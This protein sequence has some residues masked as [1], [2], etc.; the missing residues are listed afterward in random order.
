L[1]NALLSAGLSQRG[2][3]KATQIMS[4]EEV[5]KVL[6][7]DKIGRRNPDRYHFSVFGQPAENGIW[8]YRVE[9]HHVSLHF[10]IVNGKV[11]GAPTF[12]GANPHEV[13]T[14][15]RQGLR[16]LGREE[17]LARD[18]VSSLD[19]GQ[20]K[21][22]VV[23]E[24]AYKDIL[25]EASRK[26]ALEGQPSGLPAAKMTAR[27]KQLLENLLEEYVH[28]LP[29]PIAQTR[30]D[31]IKKAGTNIQFARAGPMEKGAPHYY[32]IQ[33]PAFL[34]EYDNTQNSANHSHTVWRD[35]NGDFGLDLLKM[36]YDSSHKPG[37]GE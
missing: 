8:G 16:V 26:A 32:R 2:Y 13:R 4:L 10:T 30:L 1:A 3:I 5:L 17:D 33:A 22:V 9:G 28:N 21:L 6:E 25:T 29:D 18:L 14:G 36:H 35:F 34:I 37:Q 23:S 31:Q 11:A 24:T 19:A 12:F 20:K 7:N 15:S 27:Q